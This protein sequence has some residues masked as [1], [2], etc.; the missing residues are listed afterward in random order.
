MAQPASQ[1]WQ[2]PGDKCNGPVTRFT[3]AREDGSKSIAPPC[4]R[5][6]PTDYTAEDA[7]PKPSAQVV[8][9]SAN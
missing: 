9:P 2:S 8:R 4:L 1:D 5:H 7:T 3:N 6:L